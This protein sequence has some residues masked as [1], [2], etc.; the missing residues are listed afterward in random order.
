MKAK[1]SASG[2]WF[3][4]SDHIVHADYTSPENITFADWQ[5]QCQQQ[6]NHHH[7]SIKSRSLM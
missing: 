6:H 5:Q 2:P 4:R 7:H 3:A 1:P